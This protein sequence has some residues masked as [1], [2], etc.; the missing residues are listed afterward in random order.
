[1]TTGSNYYNASFGSGK[2]R[3]YSFH[4]DKTM[5]TALWTAYPLTADHIEGSASGKTW[6]YTPGLSESVQI[7]VKS[8]SYGTNYGDDTYS[9]GHLLPAADR[10]C[11]ATMRNQTYYLTN[12]TPQNQ[13]GFNSPMWSNLEQAVRDLTSSTDTVY[14][15]TGAAFRKVGGNE[16]ISYLTGKSGITPSRVPVPNYFWK[17][18]L[19]VKRSGTKITSAKAVAVWMPHSSS[20]SY[21]QTAWQGYVCSVSEVENYTGFSFFANLPSDLASDAKSNK[22]WSTFVSF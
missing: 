12:Q 17:V 11:N 20:S 6:S 7:D 16:S 8:N 10:K 22:Y 18:L 21:A 5:Y 13:D 2:S 19:K 3:N 4:Y 14:V 9:R 1:M 15:V